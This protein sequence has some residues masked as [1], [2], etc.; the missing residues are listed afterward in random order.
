MEFKRDSV[1]TLYL[2]RKAQV[3]I[4]RI[5]RYLNTNKLFLSPILSRYHDTGNIG[6]HRERERKKMKQHQ[7]FVLFHLLKPRPY[8]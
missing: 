5:L 7:K 8:V 3:S 6:R 1:F 2:A 4:F